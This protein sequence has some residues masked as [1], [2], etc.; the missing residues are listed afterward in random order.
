MSADPLLTAHR[1]GECPR[2]CVYC[3]ELTTLHRDLV[4]LFRARR[5]DI[6]RIEAI[7]ERLAELGNADWV[8]I[9]AREADD[10]RD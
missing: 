7:V 3:A 6:D 1:A 10:D 9:A 5:H 8:Q 2:A 4:R